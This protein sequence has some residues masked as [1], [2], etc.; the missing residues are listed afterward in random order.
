MSNQTTPA[1]AKNTAA[2]TKPAAQRAPTAPA[3]ALASISVPWRPSNGYVTRSFDGRMSV[4]QGVALRLIH[5]G[6]KETGAKIHSP[7]DA[8]RFVLDRIADKIGIS[9]TGDFPGR[10]VRAG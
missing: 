8:L 10:V 2:L 9:P 7:T 6:I 4:R 3:D 5:E 1:A